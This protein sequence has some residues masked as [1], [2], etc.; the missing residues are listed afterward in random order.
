MKVKT[1]T[2]K[3]SNKYSYTVGSVLDMCRRC[4]ID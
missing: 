4:G 1:A 2:F 3:S